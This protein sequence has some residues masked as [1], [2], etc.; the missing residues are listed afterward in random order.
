MSQ[1]QDAPVKKKRPPMKEEDLKG[2][3]NKL[4]HQ[5]PIKSKTYQVMKECEQSGTMAPSV[6]SQNK[7]GGETAFD[8]PKAGPAKSV[9]G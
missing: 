3:K 9:F 5:V 1:P 4:A 7:T 2:A 8:K 6:F